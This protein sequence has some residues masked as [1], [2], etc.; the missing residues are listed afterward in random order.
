M[1]NLEE[2]L[3]LDSY[4]QKCILVSDHDVDMKQLSTWAP[5]TV[6]RFC[7]TKSNPSSFSPKVL[8]LFKMYSGQ[9]QRTLDSS[10]HRQLHNTIVG[11]LQS[12]ESL[13]DQY[14]VMGEIKFR[15]TTIQKENT[16]LKNDS[17]RN[18]EV[19]NEF[20]KYLI[21]QMFNDTMGSVQKLIIDA[22][23]PKKGFMMVPRKS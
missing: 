13:G 14:A 1:K 7:T 2:S 10:H 17:D 9:L 5:V 15:D 20:R 8:S 22:Q 3:D 4:Q 6:V 16:H 21:T 12:V 11:I 23:D 19:C 18:K